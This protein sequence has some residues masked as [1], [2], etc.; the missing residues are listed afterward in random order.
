MTGADGIVMTGADGIV[1]TGADGSTYRADSVTITL[2]N[3]IVMTGLWE[4]DA[5]TPYSG[6]FH[7]GER[8]LIIARYSTC[9][10]ETRRGH[11]R[12]VPV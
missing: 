9:C 10:T 3:G 11:M 1:M 6:Y 2:P 4:I 7:N 12:V 5:D 8:G